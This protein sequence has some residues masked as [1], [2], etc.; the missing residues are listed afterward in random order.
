MSGPCPDGCA[1]LTP[2]AEAALRLEAERC[3]GYAIDPDEATRGS[4]AFNFLADCRV[5]LVA[6]GA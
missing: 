6:A 5:V 4:A 1:D 2:R 3:G